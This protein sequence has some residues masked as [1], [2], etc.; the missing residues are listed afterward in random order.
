MLICC[1]RGEELKSAFG[2][3]PVWIIG[4]LVCKS[5]RS[6]PQDSRCIR[7]EAHADGQP[8][9]QPPIPK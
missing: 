4:E 5:F 8:L 9:G 2:W 7:A 1:R 3:R 6:L